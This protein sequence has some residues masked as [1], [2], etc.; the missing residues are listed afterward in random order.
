[1]NQRWARWAVATLLS[2]LAVP[3][4][5]AAEAGLPSAEQVIARYVEALGGEAAVRAPKSFTMR[6]RFSMPAAG[7]DG[8]FRLLSM[9]PDKQLS[10]ITLPGVG[11]IRQGF[12]GTHG[13]MLNPI[14]GPMLFEDAMLRQARF[15]ADFFAP[16]HDRRRYRSMETMAR[17]SF[18]GREAHK[19]RLVT[20]DGDEIV[21]FYD[22]ETGLLTGMEIT[23]ET[24]M[25]PQT[26]KSALFDYKVV[27]GMKLP[28]RIEQE[29]GPGMLQTVT[30]TSITRD[31]VDPAAFELPTEIRALVAGASAAPQPN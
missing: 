16:L 30:F 18:R 19:L 5:W 9:A 15:Q 26:I 24:A 21:E 27:A 25:G 23:A 17:E 1:M 28:T 29:L 2:I 3:A 10:A 31:D 13:W 22:V 4:V 20:T 6:G 12:D 7:L 8:E 14:T 11:E